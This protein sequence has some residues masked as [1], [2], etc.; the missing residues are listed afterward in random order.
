MLTN[1]TSCGRAQKQRQAV[2]FG[3]LGSVCGVF[4]GVRL[5][6]VRT[7]KYPA[8]TPQKNPA[9][10]TYSAKT[11][12]SAMRS[13]RGWLPRHFIFDIHSLFAFPVSRRWH[14]CPYWPISAPASTG[15]SCGNR[16]GT[17]CRHGRGQNWVK[18]YSCSFGRPS[19]RVSLSKS[20]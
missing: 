15:V 6:G 4:C 13:A 18:G 7:R 5:C 11:D 3:Q 16:L 14:R 12:V 19:C 8:N 2:F 10:V 9:R 1:P 17:R 20:Q